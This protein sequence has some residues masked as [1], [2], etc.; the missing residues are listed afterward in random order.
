MMKFEMFL[1]YYFY[2]IVIDYK[3]Q[4]IIHW[5]MQVFLKLSEQRI[6]ALLLHRIRFIRYVNISTQIILIKNIPKWK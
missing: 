6:F 1:Y 4:I 2:N 3:I 5:K